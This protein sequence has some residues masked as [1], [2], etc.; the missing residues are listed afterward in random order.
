[1]PS[2]FI[3]IGTQQIQLIG[4]LWFMLPRLSIYENDFETKLPD[5]FSLCRE[6]LNRL[7]PVKLAMLKSVFFATKVRRY[8][9]HLPRIHS[10]V[11]SK[12][13]ATFALRVAAILNAHA[14]A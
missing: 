11:I 5:L 2:D 3:V 12:M 10:A 4:I 6:R 9:N 13:T 1:M 7:K 14:L 8:F